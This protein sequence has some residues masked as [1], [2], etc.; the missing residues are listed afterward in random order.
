MEHPLLVLFVINPRRVPVY[1]EESYSGCDFLGNKV[2]KQVIQWKMKQSVNWVLCCVF[3]GCSKLF[4]LSFWEICCGPPVRKSRKLTRQAELS[5]PLAISS[6][7]S[8]NWRQI[9]DVFHLKNTSIQAIRDVP[10]PSPNLSIIF[11]EFTEKGN[12]ENHNKAFSTWSVQETRPKE[13]KAF[14]SIRI[15]QSVQCNPWQFPAPPGSFQWS[16]CT[17]W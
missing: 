4:L 11:R 16:G 7:S 1:P 15:H 5:C 9:I 17:H 13:F 12:P 8:W 2:W 3:L 10:I 6:C 14:E